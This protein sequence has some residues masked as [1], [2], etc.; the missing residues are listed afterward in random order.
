MRF[1]AKILWLMLW[2]VC[3][4]QDCKEPPPRKETEILSGTWQEQS[5]PEG[6]QATYKCRPGYRTF[7]SIFMQCRKGE[8]VALNPS[9]TCRKRPCGHPG[10]I[11]FGSFHLEEG[12]EFVYGAK[13]VY[14]CDEGYQLVGE[15]NFRKCEADGWTNDVPMCEVAKCLP[16]TEPENGRIISSAVELNQEYTFGQ[17]VQ[18][19]CNAGFMLDR[20]K[21]IHC[22]A[23]GVWSGETPNC[24]AISCKLPEISHGVPMNPKNTYKENDRLQ[25]K[26]HSGFGYSERADTICTKFGWSPTPSCKEIACDP[27]YIPNGNYSPQRTK[28]RLENVI[29]YQCKN[30]FSPATRGNTVRCTS[31]GWEPH[32]RC[33]FQPCAFPEIK[34]G[35]LHNENRYK[36]YFP[37]AVGKWYYYSCNDN[38][39]THSRSFW[40]HITC[41]REGWSPAVPCRRRCLFR[42]VV[43]GYTPSSEEYHKDYFQGDTVR[44]ECHPG[45]SLPNEQTSMTCTENGWSPPPTCIP[46][47][48]CSK[49]DLEIP[50]GFISESDPTYPVH[51]R[52]QYKCKQGY[53]TTDGHT[54][55]SITCQ[56]NGWSAQPT[57]I[58]RECTVPDIEKHVVAEPRK[59]TYRVGDVLKFSCRNRLQIVGPDSSQCYHFGWSP[60]P[61]TCKEQVKSCGLRPELPNGEA[62]STPKEEYQHGEVVEYVCKPRFLMK[63]SHRVQCL[64]GEWTTLPMCIEEDSTCGDVPALAYGHVVSPAAPYHHGDSVEFNCSEAFTMIGHRSVMC[65]RG[66]WT[67]PPRCIETDE[68]KKCKLSKS[69]ARETN[70]SDNDDYTHNMN[71]TYT[72]RGKSEHRHS[73]CKNGEWDPE[74]TCTEVRR[75]PPPPQIPKTEKMTTTVNYQDGEKIS[76][77]CQENSLIQGPEEIECKDGIWQ[78]IPRCVEKLPCSQPPHIEH[79]TVNSSISSGE[80]DEEHEP[81]TYTHGTKLN[82]TCEDGFRISAEDGITCH[83]GTWTSPPRCIGLP[84]VPP[85]LIGNGI[86]P[87]KLTSYPYGIE[88][89]YRCSKGF[90][91]DGPASVKCIGERWSRPP[92]CIKAECSD[93]PRIANAILVSKWKK[94][95]SSG[96]ELTYKCDEYYQMEGSNIVQCMKGKWIGE[97]TC[98]DVSCA[99]PPTV[100]NARILDEM[101]KYM[102]GDRVSYECIRPLA[103]FGNGEVMCLNGS[104][105]EP[106][107]CKESER[108]CGPPPPIQSGDIT[109]FPLA[110][111]APG[112]SVEYQCQFL[113]ELQGN[114]QITCRDGKW[115]EPPKC[116]EAKCSDPPRIA[117]AI[118]VSKRKKSYSSGEELTYKCDEYYQ[119][120]GSNIVQ[121]MKGKWI[122]EPTCRDVSC[123]NPPTVENARI[124]DGMPRYISGDRVRYECIRPL[125]LFGNREVMCLDGTWSEPPQ[126]K[127]SKGKCGPPPPIPNGDITT[128]PLAEYAPGSSVEYQC[129]FLYE[130]QGNKQI[131]CRDG[132]WSE[133]PKCLDACIVSEEI[134][135]KHHI[136]FKWTYEKKLYSRTD[137]FVEFVCKSGY[138]EHSPKTAFRA[139]CR[140]GKLEYPICVR[141]WR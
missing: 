34:H 133:P 94:S 125:A 57:C 50:N 8:W 76:I 17:V 19:E 89:T 99:N 53:V 68:R 141:R 87:K 59:D 139:R 100:E 80:G 44:V 116:F 118:L 82:Y 41:T 67:Q 138:R 31:V 86:G 75:C 106:P 60:D 65:I 43:H 5:Y 21:E 136:Q 102:S 84:C 77:L 52:V 10:D 120:E 28:Y 104:W 117:N 124:L 123:A 37:A 1:A 22:S 33:T 54:T 85:P 71:V 112:S 131:T 72:C 11:A 55:G 32:P 47:K 109:T 91:I 20:P 103:L 79:G 4:A 105:T 14:T 111:Y 119:M 24:V 88:V 98:R 40:D 74:V 25:Y 129:R 16:V 27:P 90:E 95:Y 78:P 126:C 83:M 137:D 42:Y 62:K 110:E 49:S 29:T 97:P 39:V 46:V 36:P 108:K 70:L 56:Q 92:E 96:E 12:D 23:N 93:P 26:C 9:K 140:E 64:D 113:Y 127:E 114:K 13:V 135:E 30:G 69:I 58:K 134:M 107:Q 61:P 81:H 6:T 101:P 2:T 18:F 121:C 73:I 132:E 63:G 35:S 122:G 45:Y 15:I 38:F 3:V 130:L 7:G 128:F 48:T 115:S 51:K 66:N